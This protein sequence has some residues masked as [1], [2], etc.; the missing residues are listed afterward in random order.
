ME[1]KINKKIQCYTRTF[2]ENLIDKIQ[3][4]DNTDNV[5][6]VVSFIKDYEVLEVTKED[7]CKS[8]RAKNNVNIQERCQ[9]LRANNTQCTRRKQKGLC[10]CGTHIKGTP[11]GKVTELSSVC[12]DVEEINIY[13]QEICGINYYIDSY[14]NIY[15][16]EDILNN[17]E[18]PT[19]IGK[20]S[21]VEENGERKYLRN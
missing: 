18:S 11:Y 4:I 2:K 5:K 9:A 14:E 10:F 8:R 12:K 3:S 16:S 13:I 15:S 19:I 20:Y 6:Y 17:I 21:I 7:L 1:I